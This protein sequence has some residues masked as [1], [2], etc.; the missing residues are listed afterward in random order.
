MTQASHFTAGFIFLAFAEKLL[1]NLLPSFHNFVVLFLQQLVF[2]FLK[3][4]S[5][6]KKIFFFTLIIEIKF[7]EGIK[8]CCMC[9]VGHLFPRGKLKF[10]C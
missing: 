6:L 1:V 5:S 3:V 9:S 10:I 2:F 4:H 7:Q 8:G